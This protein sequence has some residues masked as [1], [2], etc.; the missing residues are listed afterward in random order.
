MST[1]TASP[2]A[3]SIS[4]VVLIAPISDLAKHYI[5]TV[6]ITTDDKTLNM[7]LFGVVSAVV[8]LIAQI[9]VSGLLLQIPRYVRWWIF[10]YVNRDTPVICPV[11]SKMLPDP[12]LLT[13]R[14]DIAALCH[15]IK[16]SNKDTKIFIQLWAMIQTSVAT[17]L[18]KY[19]AVDERRKKVYNMLVNVF[20]CM[21]IQY[22]CGHIAV[23]AHCACYHIY[24]LYVDSC[25][26]GSLATFYC[27]NRVALDIFMAYIE[28]KYKELLQPRENSG[29]NTSFNVY[30]CIAPM[31][32]DSGIQLKEVGKIK[33]SYNFENYVSR[34]KVMLLKKLDAFKNMRLYDMNPYVDNNIGLLLYGHYGTGKTYLASAIANYLGRDLCIVNFAVIKTR[35]HYREIMLNAE[36]YVYLFDEFDYLLNDLLVAD[37]KSAKESA[38]KDNALKIA[39]LTAQLN[40]TIETAKKDEIS[41]ELKALMESGASDVLTYEFILSELSG[42]TSVSDR[43]IIATTNHMEKIPPALLRPGRFDIKLHLDLFNQSEIVELLGKLYKL[44]AEQEEVLRKSKD[45]FKE[46]QYS[47]ADIINKSCIYTFDEIVMILK[48]DSN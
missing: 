15:V 29:R 18:A 19:N 28:C 6:Y 1:T 3:L 14:A 25:K 44:T 30:E 12:Y 10:R 11:V 2:S 21:I 5:N 17:K 36:Q 9:M 42:V 33:A 26:V 39:M 13:N 27:I 41:K 31:S 37:D 40:A 24:M 48:K 32:A 35:T 43:V 47:P 34:H 23:V 4:V 8:T 45:A 22:D 7:L 46:G 38:K 20:S 16:F